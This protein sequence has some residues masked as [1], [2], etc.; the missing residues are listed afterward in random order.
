MA[1]ST[2]VW[3]RAK[4]TILSDVGGVKQIDDAGVQTID[5]YMTLFAQFV[6]KKGLISRLQIT[7]GFQATL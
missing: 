2:D 4:Q 5:S 1:R 3:Q 6:E 7:K